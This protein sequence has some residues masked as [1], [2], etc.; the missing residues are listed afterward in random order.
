MEAIYGI[1]ADGFLFLILSLSYYLFRMKEYCKSLLAFYN[2]KKRFLVAVV[3]IRPIAIKYQIKSN[4]VTS[5][6]VVA[7]CKE[8]AFI[9][10]DHISL[11]GHSVKLFLT[12]GIS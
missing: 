8:P 10:C 7:C 5:T 12:N 4:I 2:K 6:W 1:L 11:D 3:N 9:L